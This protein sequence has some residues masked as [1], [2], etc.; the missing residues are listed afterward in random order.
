[1]LSA[2]RIFHEIRDHDEAYRLFLSIAAKGEDQGGWE[3]ERIAALTHDPELAAKIARHGEDE[4]KHGRLFA[5]LLRRRDLE[6]LPVPPEVDYCMLLEQQGIGL[7]HARLQ[8]EEPL[9]VEE[10]L[11]YLAHS[12]VTEQRAAEEIELQKRIFGTDPEIGRAVRMI[13]DDEENHLAYCHEELL[14]LADEGHAENIRAMLRR[15]ALAEIRTY[16]D[17]SLGV[18][19]HM[20]R[21]L[22]WPRW[23]RGVLAA[24]IRAVYAI[25]RLFT[26]RRMVRLRPPARRNAMAPRGA[27]PAGVD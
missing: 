22:A 3:N 24:A 16:R 12:R 5:A 6:P 26:W 27:A 14:R 7:S 9:G 25:E 19:G 18:M 17:V 2:R 15:Y 4:A 21:I 23:K 11:A 20:G 8:R 13:A 10:I 1:M